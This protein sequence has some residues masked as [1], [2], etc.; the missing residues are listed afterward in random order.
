MFRGITDEDRALTKKCQE[1][2]LAKDE[3]AAKCVSCGKTFN[4]KQAE[5]VAETIFLGHGQSE[6]KHYCNTCWEEKEKRKVGKAERGTGYKHSDSIT[7]VRRE[8]ERRLVQDRKAPVE[9][10]SEKLRALESEINSLRTSIAHGTTED[11][12]SAA[13]HLRDLEE[14]KKMLE[15]RPNFMTLRPALQTLEDLRLK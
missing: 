5:G 9:E 13:A 6:I 10:R 1:L 8:T 14:R 3:S 15:L 4:M 12:Y 2:Q 11:L 7:D